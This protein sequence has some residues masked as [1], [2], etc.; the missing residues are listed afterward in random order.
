M[1]KPT[2]LFIG[3][4]VHKD[5]MAVAHA[6]GTQRQPGSGRLECGPSSVPRGGRVSHAGAADRVSGIGS[7]P[8]TAGGSGASP[9]SRAARAG[10][11]V[12]ARRDYQ[13]R[14]QPRRACADRVST[15]NRKSTDI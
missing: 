10:T 6:E 5:S 1:V 2:P 7:A 14:E 15:A 12:A 4:D 11:R 9:R 8:S 3:L 13:H